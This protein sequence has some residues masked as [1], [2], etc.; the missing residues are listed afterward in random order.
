MA[1]EVQRRGGKFEAIGFLLILLGMAGCFSAASIGG[2]GLVIG[3]L[4]A[5]IGLI[6][7]LIGRFM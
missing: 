6:V 5:G 2:A 4:L 7:F 3:S 1:T